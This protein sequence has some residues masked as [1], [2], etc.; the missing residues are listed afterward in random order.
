MILPSGLKLD[1]QKWGIEASP[2]RYRIN[3]ST[4]QVLKRHKITL[5]YLSQKFW[6]TQLNQNKLC[7]PVLQPVAHPLQPPHALNASRH[8]LP[9]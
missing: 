9:I 2:I 7:H 6:K 4:K 1:C 5:E 3:R 8:S